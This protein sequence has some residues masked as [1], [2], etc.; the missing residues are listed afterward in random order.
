M[1][2]HHKIMIVGLVLL[3]VGLVL[4]AFAVF[5]LFP[6]PS[7]EAEWDGSFGSGGGSRDID[8]DD[9]TY[10]VWVS[11]AGSSVRV[12]VEDSLGYTEFDGTSS[13]H[14]ESININGKDYYKLGSFHVDGGKYTVETDGAAE[15]YIT[16]PLDIWGAIGATC[17]AG[18]SILIGIIMIA[19]GGVQW[20]V[21]SFKRGPEPIRYHD[22]PR[23]SPGPYRR[24]PDEY[25]GPYREEYAPPK[26]DYR[27][28]DE[29]HRRERR[30]PPPRYD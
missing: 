14:S 6:D 3:I 16:P 30:P 1:K 20:L 17:G 28:Q 29:Y 8:L 19:I 22:A 4:S 7:E 12:T 21:K 15:V 10:D 25:H 11:D 27:I 2:G 24:E 13:E 5:T 9:G 18:I 23:H 26:G